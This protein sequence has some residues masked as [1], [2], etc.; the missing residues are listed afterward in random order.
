MKSNPYASSGV[1]D[2]LQRRGLFNVLEATVVKGLYDRIRH[3]ENEVADRAD[4]HNVLKEAR[5]TRGDGRDDA[6]RARNLAPNAAVKG[7]DIL[8]THY[9]VRLIIRE[10]V[11][12]RAFPRPRHRHVADR[13]VPLL[14]PE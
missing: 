4:L 7:L 8:M 14:T 2:L 11:D 6:D 9:R 5:V 1:V 13:V 10:E 3:A 12:R